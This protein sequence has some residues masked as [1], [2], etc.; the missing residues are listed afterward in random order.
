MSDVT[1]VDATAPDA[2]KS[3]LL[4]P[5]NLIT[6]VILAGG[7]MILAIRFIHGLA[8]TTNLDPTTTRGACG[9]GSTS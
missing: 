5:F 1:A 3:G 2:G 8:A 7:A 4:T 9:S 6:G